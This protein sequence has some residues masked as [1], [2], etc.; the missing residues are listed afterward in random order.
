MFHK[1]SSELIRRA[2]DLGLLYELRK[3]SDCHFVQLNFLEL[4]MKLKE[5]RYVGS[6]SRLSKHACCYLFRR[7][8]FSVRI[9]PIC[10]ITVE[11]LSASSFHFVPVFSKEQRVRMTNL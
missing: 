5:I 3:D 10:D 8:Q 7:E 1:A 4:K 9:M 11:C 2:R 6:S